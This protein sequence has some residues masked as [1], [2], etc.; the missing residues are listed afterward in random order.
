[1]LVAS[2][3]LISSQ[4]ANQLDQGIDFVLGYEISCQSM[5]PRRVTLRYN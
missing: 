1:M 3:V 2:Y 5:I 4:G